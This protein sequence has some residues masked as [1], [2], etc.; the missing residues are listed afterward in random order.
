[1]NEIQIIILSNFLLVVSLDCVAA[2]RASETKLFL[3]KVLIIVYH[4][5]FG[6]DLVIVIYIVKVLIFIKN[7][8]FIIE[9]N[10]AQPLVASIQHN[11]T[12]P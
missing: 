8:T 3:D 11:H 9:H 1:M 7:T 12:I 10:S 2:Y 6:N 5:Y 4:L